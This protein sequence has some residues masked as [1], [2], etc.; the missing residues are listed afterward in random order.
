MEPLRGG[1]M[2]R[3]LLSICLFLFA[4]QSFSK[5]SVPF[6]VMTYNMHGIPCIDKKKYSKIFKEFSIERCPDNTYWSQMIDE[7]FLRLSQI[8]RQMSLHGRL[9]DVL[10]LQEAFDT[11]L[12]LMDVSALNNLLENSP[13]SYYVQGPGGRVHN[14]VG[15][16]LSY[17]FQIPGIVDSGLVVLSKHPIRRVG[18]KAFFECRDTDCLANKG[19][20]YAQVDLPGTNKTIDIFNTHYQAGQRF[21]HIKLGHNLKSQAYLRKIRSRRYSDVQIYGGD[22]NFRNRSDFPSF[23]DFLEKSKMAH[24]GLLCAQMGQGCGWNSRNP[25]SWIEGA[26]LDHQFVSRMKKD[27]HIYPRHMEYGQFQ[28]NAKPLTDHHYLI[29]DYDIVV[30]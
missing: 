2:F 11:H 27:V 25:K 23:Q 26:L 18:R 3:C 12:P 9:P 15:A 6:T 5:T 16:A 4:S 20:L 22:F 19:I 24:A 17:L 10:L 7:R 30:P 8:L 1:T 14:V 29:V 13:Y 21:E 28:W